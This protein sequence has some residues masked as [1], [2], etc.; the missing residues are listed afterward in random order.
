MRALGRAGQKRPE[1]R[2]LPLRVKIFYTLTASEAHVV[3][4]PD[5]AAGAN[6]PSI[7]NPLISLDAAVWHAYCINIHID[8]PI[9]WRLK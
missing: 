1:G 6:P 7:S 5:T 8:E 4:F 9:L 2:S 3:K